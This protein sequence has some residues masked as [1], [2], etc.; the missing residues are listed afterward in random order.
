[1]SATVK[2]RDG[3]TIHYREGTS[4][5]KA[6]REACG[7]VIDQ[8]RRMSGYERIRDPVLRIEEGDTWLDLGSQIGSFTLRAAKNGACVI[9]VEPEPQNAKL[10]RKNVRE[11]KLAARAK[12]VQ[13]ACVPDSRR[14]VTLNIATSTY[15]H[16]LL[17]MAKGI[18]SVQVAAI[19]LGSLLKQHPK[20]NA[21]KMDVEGSE[22][23]LLRSVSWKDTGVEK[24]V[25]EYSFDHDQNLSHFYSLIDYM[26]KHFDRV[27]FHKI[28]FVG[29][30]DKKVTRG[31]D[32]RLVWCVK[33][34]S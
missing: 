34:A 18:G 5:I 1:M 12:L 22:T 16:S 25:F 10:W 28:S 9:A 19:N 21:V 30:W 2:T 3:L 31:A 23:V 6:I 29:T 17:D 4:D 24:L 33:G 14:T 7:N 27:H 13:K 32:G 20:V 26:R 15:K 11:N 8:P